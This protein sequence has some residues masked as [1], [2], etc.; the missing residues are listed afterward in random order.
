MKKLDNMERWLLVFIVV[1][2]LIGYL[3]HNN[4]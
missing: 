3:R 1:M 2:I 4:F